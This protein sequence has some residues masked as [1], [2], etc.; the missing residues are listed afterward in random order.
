MTLRDPKPPRYP[1][2]EPL[3]SQACRYTRELLDLDTGKETQEIFA[4][5]ISV[6]SVIETALMESASFR[7]III[8]APTFLIRQI[9]TLTEEIP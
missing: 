3:R 2:L 5:P 7:Q 8:R 4:F 9:A 1:R 6:F